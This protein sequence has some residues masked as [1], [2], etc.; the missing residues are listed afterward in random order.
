MTV[1]IP[2]GG[3]TVRRRTTCVLSALIPIALLFFGCRSESPSSSATSGETEPSPTAA[4]QAPAST[5]D[6][7]ETGLTLPATFRSEEASSSREPVAGKG[8]GALTLRLMPDGTFRLRD[9]RADTTV[10][11]LGRWQEVIGERRLLLQGSA[12]DAVRVDRISADTLQVRPREGGGFFPSRNGPVR[13]VHD[14]ASVDSIPGPMQLQGMY[15]YYADTGRFV[16]CWTGRDV[17]VVQEADNAALER[18]YLENADPPNPVLARVD[19][20]LEMRPRIEGEGKE[21]VLVVDRFR[22]VDP[23]A[24]CSGLGVMDTVASLDGVRWNLVQVGDR[25]L[26]AGHAQADIR[27]Q[28]ADSSVV[29]SGGCNRLRAGYRTRTGDRITFLQPLTTKR[30]CAPPVM[31]LEEALVA[32]LDSATGYRLTRSSLEILHGVDRLVRFQASER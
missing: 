22:E 25:L 28:P 21:L 8:A 1:S 17:R 12:V 3:R 6:S 18:G 26:P 2:D 15:T 7:V 29:G 14:S 27:F 32:A 31:R 24:S 23:D 19:G 4:Q 5:A 11:D 16:E 30:M 13:L 20:R 10:Y 9:R